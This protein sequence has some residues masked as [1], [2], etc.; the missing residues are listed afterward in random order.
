MTIW[1]IKIR[2]CFGLVYIFRCFLSVS[3]ICT[4]QEA[5]NRKEFRARIFNHF[6]QSNVNLLK[7]SKFV[8]RTNNI[9]NLNGIARVERNPKIYIFSNAETRSHRSSIWDAHTAHTH[10]PKARTKN[11]HN[12]YPKLP[13]PIRLAVTSKGKPKQHKRKQNKTITFAVHSVRPAVR[14]RPRNAIILKF[15]RSHQDNEMT[16]VQFVYTRF[17]VYVCRARCRCRCARTDRHLCATKM[18]RNDVDGLKRTTN[19][20]NY[21]YICS[22]FHDFVIRSIAFCSL[23][24]S[25][26]LSARLEPIPRERSM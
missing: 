15:K 1:I 20:S 6:D 24:I 18:V 26:I 13:E 22:C 10:N 9:G 4:T 3:S 5:Q 8:R 19:Q 25:F 7:I 14:P 23:L 2:V 12:E 21:Y 16:I 11:T 17:L